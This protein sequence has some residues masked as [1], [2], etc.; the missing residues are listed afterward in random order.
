MSP[1][2]TLRAAL[3]LGSSSLVLG[4]VRGPEVKVLYEAMQIDEERHILFFAFTFT[5]LGYFS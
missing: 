3:R 2:T 5:L 1:E 4:E